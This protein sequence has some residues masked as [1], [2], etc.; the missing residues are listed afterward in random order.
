MT[1][2]AGRLG[3]LPAVAALITPLLAVA[4]AH[5]GTGDCCTANGTPGC[6]QPAC[7]A[8]VCP[9]D[10]FCCNI[11]WDLLC[12]N[13]AAQLCDCEN[14]SDICGV[15]TNDCFTVGNGPGCSDIEC[16]TLICSVD[17]QCCTVSWDAGCASNATLF[18]DGGPIDPPP[19]SGCG[20]AENDCFESGPVAGCSD[21]ACCAAVCAIDLFCCNTQWDLLCVKAALDLCEP[22]ESFESCLDATSDCSIAS[23]TP[24]CSDADCCTSVCSI[25]PACC[26]IGWDTTCVQTALD[27]CDLAPSCGTS[28]NDCFLPGTGS[29]CSD[30]LCCQQVCSFAPSCCQVEWDQFC[31]SVAVSICDGAPVEPSGCGIS[32]NT[33]F[34]TS[35]NPGCADENCCEAICAVDPFCC[36]IAWDIL[37]AQAAEASCEGGGQQPPSVCGSATN[38]C[39]E[40]GGPGCSSAACCQFVCAQDPLCCLVAWDAL[41]V[42]AAEE[43]CVPAGQL[44]SICGAATH[45]CAEVGGPGCA[46]ADC[47][48]AVCDFAPDCCMV[49]W[50]AMCVELASRS[51]SST[52][53]ADLNADGFV[54]GADL[55]ILLASWGACANCDADLDGSGAVDAADLA[56]LLAAWNG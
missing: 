2:F 32:T 50:D 52:P 10:P 5:A 24:G 18:C 11:E 29:G 3:R 6:D 45:G 33:C 44:E 13:L 53:T 16:C 41:C 42:S 17:I 34:T 40:V 35:Q 28:D 48:A 21:A 25:D 12:A 7:E 54:N 43:F 38:D 1:L 51:C 46:D 8:V 49:A 26:V 4:V 27:L 37:C 20:I 15:S 19:P 30:E 55:G 14:P 36:N 31:A 9:Q 39:F 47:C 23:N 56:V 22:G